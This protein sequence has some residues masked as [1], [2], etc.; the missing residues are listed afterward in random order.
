MTKKELQEI[1]FIKREIEHLK[2]Q[3]ENMDYYTSDNYASDSVKGSLPVFP[4]IEHTVIIR[5]YEVVDGNGRSYQR[6]LDSLHRKLKERSE[7]LIEKVDKANDFIAKIESAELRLIISLRY[8][9]GMTWEQI[10]ADIGYAAI[11]VRKKH[12]EFMKMYQLIS[13]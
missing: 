12:D 13:H 4:Y 11:T 5:G 8:I 2:W 9:N 7:D 3:I 1:H 6:K 10:G